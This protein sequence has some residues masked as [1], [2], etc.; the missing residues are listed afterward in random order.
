MMKNIKVVI[1]WSEPIELFKPG[2]YNTEEKFIYHLR[3]MLT[4]NESPLLEKKGFFLFLSGSFLPEEKLS[5]VLIGYS[6]ENSIKEEIRKLKGHVREFKCIYRNYKNENLYLKTGIIEQLNEKESKEL[7]NNI[8]CS[9]VLS[10]F[11]SCNEPCKLIGLTDIYIKNIG[12]F[13]PLKENS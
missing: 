5:A 2:K 1:K 7:Y 12:N 8:L 3:K 9:L 10:N 4:E 11:P 13:S 6:F